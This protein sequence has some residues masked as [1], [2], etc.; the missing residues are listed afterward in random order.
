MPD[1]IDT[2][3]EQEECILTMRLA[4]HL[5]GLLAAQVEAIIQQGRDCSE[6]GLPIPVARLRAN[7]MAHRC[8]DC[9]E[10]FERG[11]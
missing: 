4:S 3:V 9:Q 5:S 8:I 10:D 2:T 11:R 1:F 7:P 6:C